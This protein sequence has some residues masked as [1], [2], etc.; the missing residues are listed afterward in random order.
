MD[1][2]IGR[3]GSNPLVQDYLSGQGRCSE[4]F[5]L[6][7]R[8][9]ASYKARAEALTAEGRSADWAEA[10]HTAGP[11]AQA[12][13]DAA[14]AQGGYVVTT[15]Q[16]PGLFTGPLYSLWKALTAIRLADHLQDKLGKPVLPLFWVASEDHDWEETNHTWLV[17][18]DNE[19]HRIALEDIDGAGDAPLFRLSIA[20]RVEAVLEQAKA[21]LP[22]TEMAGEALTM[23]R[24]AYTSSG[25]TP[26]TLGSGFQRILEALVEPLGMAFTQ[27]HDPALKHLSAPVFKAAYRSAA[28]I[29]SVMATRATELE[30]AG[31][32]VQVPIME[33]GVNLFLEADGQRERLYRDG[34]GYV[35]RHSGAGFTADELDAIV[36]SDPGRL[37][38]NVHLRPLVEATVFP[39]LAYVAGPGELTYYGQL[40]PFYDALGI[41]MPVIYPRFGVTLYEKKVAKVLDKFDIEESS[42]A[43]P[44]HEIAQDFARDEVPEGVREALGRIRGAI[45]EGTN[46]LIEA[47]K[48]IDPTLK[49]PISSAR[50]A[51][52]G[53]FADAEKN[54]LK[55]VKRESETTLQQIE[56]AQLHLFPDGKPQERMLSPIYYL[57]RYGAHFVREVAEGIQI[58]LPP[59]SE[60]E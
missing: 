55:A 10:V 43:R 17:G 16:Q 13:L 57:A 42:L 41:G 35:L 32:P 40:Q 50:G 53:A 49:G 4:F 21:L 45:G 19:L 39:T 33:G 15:G 48:D 47:S 12:R 28:K 9:L 1:F 46:A 5:P 27:A 2:K 26:V 20:E 51:A 60:K 44:F 7:W 56:K 54:I 24:A 14:V 22:E 6:D 23:L 18:V 58:S 38:P 37:S 36:D 25:D 11:T 59:S 8:A 29:E 31:Y 3:P 30:S 34:D 52:L